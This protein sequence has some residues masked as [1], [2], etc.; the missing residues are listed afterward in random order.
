MFA[1]NAVPEIQFRAPEGIRHDGLVVLGLGQS[2]GESAFG[3]EPL[4]IDDP[5]V[6]ERLAD[7]LMAQLAAGP[8]SLAKGEMLAQFNAFVRARLSNGSSALHTQEEWEAYL[9]EAIALGVRYALP[10]DER[11]ARALDEMQNDS[12]RILGIDAKAYIAWEEHFGEEFVSAQIFSP[13][14]GILADRESPKGRLLAAFEDHMGQ[15]AEKK[16]GH[17]ASVLN[18]GLSDETDLQ[19]SIARASLI[20]G[21]AEKIDYASRLI[22]LLRMQGRRGMASLALMLVFRAS[23]SSEYAP[24]RDA[25]LPRWSK[26]EIVSVIAGL[27]NDD[28]WD[29]VNHRAFRMHLTPAENEYVNRIVE[30]A[31]F[32]NAVSTLR[33]ID[34]STASD[35][36]FWNALEGSGQAE[37]ILDNVVNKMAYMISPAIVE[38]S[39]SDELN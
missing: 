18:V 20:P 9:R 2:G 12:S 19:W 25:F 10:F 34:L 4:T 8:G 11:G 7:L 31:N 23:N 32:Q 21:L 24:R 30:R 35:D 37:M 27:M 1:V 13:E 22:A 26:R 5:E 6:V 17:S 38:N 36:E 3:R 15:V 39:F 28:T 14:G 33:G 29:V 16:I